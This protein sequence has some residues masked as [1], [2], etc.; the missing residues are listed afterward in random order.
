MMI[1]L[2]ALNVFL[3]CQVIWYRVAS[4]L[5]GSAAVGTPQLL[6]Q[7]LCHLRISQSSLNAVLPRPPHMQSSSFAR[8][9]MIKPGVLLR[10]VSNAVVLWLVLAI[11]WMTLPSPLVKN[12]PDFYVT[13]RL[14]TGKNLIRVYE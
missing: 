8:A 1:K 12:G 7:L 2:D 10:V 9:S 14:K 13:K 11:L 6:C 3:R 5:A 4:S